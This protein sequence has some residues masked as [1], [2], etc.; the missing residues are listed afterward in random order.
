MKT[1]VFS[2]LHIGS[3]QSNLSVDKVITVVCG[4]NPNKVIF[5]GDT[6]DLSVCESNEILIWDLE[7][8]LKRVGV[9]SVFING[10]HEYGFFDLDGYSYKDNNKDIFIFHGH[11]YEPWIVEVI[12]PILIK[13]NE[14]IL[15]LTGFNFQYWFRE[16]GEADFP[17]GRFLPKLY[18]QRAEVIK[19]LKDYDIVISGHTHYPEV[20]EFEDDKIYANPGNWESYLIVNN[21]QVELRR[22]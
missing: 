2:D 13:I 10:N 15:N 16:K 22:I 20:T 5:A 19:K 8:E 9:K 17:E 14:F 4:E 18:N 11:Q 1:L 3:K 7:C 6:V 21:G 12:D